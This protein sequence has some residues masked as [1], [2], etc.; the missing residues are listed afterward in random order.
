MA[1]LV[2]RRRI[3]MP[4][5]RPG[6]VIR[7]MA[8]RA[9]L[10]PDGT[11]VFMG[12]PRNLMEYPGESVSN[13]SLYHALYAAGIMRIGRHQQATWIIPAVLMKVH[14]QRKSAGGSAS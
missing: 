2:A 4:Q 9:T 10:Q 1:D 12:S 11:G 13:G 7:S 6:D 8:L 5:Q 3:G 14:R